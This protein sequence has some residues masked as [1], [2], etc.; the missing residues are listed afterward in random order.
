[1]G[2]VMSYALALTEP[3]RVRGVVAHSGYIPEDT[4]LGFAWKNLRGTAFFVAHGT[5]DPV[6]DVRFAR[7]AKDLLS[8]KAP[9]TYKEYSIPH[10]M[11]EESVDDCASWLRKHLESPAE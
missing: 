10:S 7:R 5:H 4:N 9:L 2:A 11:S 3:D 1:M 6:I 8:E